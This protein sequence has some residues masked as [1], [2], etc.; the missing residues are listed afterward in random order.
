MNTFSQLLASGKP[1]L[2]DGATGTNLFKKGLGPGDPPELWNV[3]NTQAISEHYASFV[4]AGADIILTNT[5]GANRYRLKLH[6][7]QDR[8]I[9]LNRAAAELAH[10]VIKASGR[11]VAVAG[12][13]GPTGEILEPSG[14]LTKDQAIE[15]FK[16]QC[17]GLLAGGVDVFWIETM[18]SAEEIE[19]AVEACQ[20]FDLPIVFTASIDTNGK[21]MM[22]ISSAQVVEIAKNLGTPCA[23][24]TN[25]GVGA[26]EV[27]A[28]IE[29]MNQAREGD[30]TLALVA[31]ANCGIPQFVGG[32][33]TYNGTPE[34]M[35][36]Y[37]HLAL[38]AGARI[39]GGCCGTSPEHLAAMRQALDNY[40]PQTTPSLE[41]IEEKLGEVSEGMKRQMRG[42]ADPSSSRRGGRRRR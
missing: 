33:V 31:K 15:A 38:D 20:Q 19:A 24:G 18:S 41:L 16:E 35:A 37:A 26:S 8:T 7:A 30:N 28:A 14:S 17:E 3:D 9:E 23:C 10:E 40:Q 11:T 22:G 21:T 13:I 27:V 6:Q 39:I 25:C 34:L 5:F 32:E 12:S 42:E 4:D 2:A 1:L 36:E 29:Q